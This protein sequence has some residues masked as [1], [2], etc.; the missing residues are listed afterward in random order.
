MSS[1]KNPSEINRLQSNNNRTSTI[2]QVSKNAKTQPPQP[3]FINRAT[4]KLPFRLSQE[5]RKRV[6]LI[7]L[8][9]ARPG[10]D[11]KLE[12]ISGVDQTNF[13]FSANRDGEYRFVFALVYDNNLVKPESPEKVAPHQ[14]IIVDRIPPQI[15]CRAVTAANGTTYLQCQLQDAHPLL[16]SLKIRFRDA[17]GRE[18]PLTAVSPESP[19][20]FPLPNGQKNSGSFV[21][22]AEDRAGNIV[23]QVIVLDEQGQG[24]IVPNRV[25]NNAQSTELV[26][27]VRNNPVNNPIVPGHVASHKSVDQQSLPPDLRLPNSK[28]FSSDSGN[29]PSGVNSQVNN[30]APIPNLL[31]PGKGNQLTPK[32]NSLLNNRNGSF[33]KFPSSTELVNS[34]ANKGVLPTGY[35]SP[36]SNSFPSNSSSLN[37]RQPNELPN[38]TNSWVTEKPLERNR[39]DTNLQNISPTP[40]SGSI[41]TSNGNSSLNKPSNYNSSETIPMP[42]IKQGTNINDDRLNQTE[43]LLGGGGNVPANLPAN[44]LAQKQPIE[45]QL[46]ITPTWINVPRCRLNYTIENTDPDVQNKTEFWATRD[47]GKTWSQLNNLAEAANQSPALLP[48]P[49]EGIFGIVIRANGNGTPPKSNEKPDCW[50]GVDTTKPLVNLLSTTLGKGEDKGSLLIVWSALDKNLL[51]DSIEIKYAPKPEGPWQSIVQNFRNDGTYRWLLPMGIPGHIYIRIEAS[52]LAG[53]RSSAMSPEPINLQIGQ[54]QVK[55]LGISPGR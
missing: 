29:N 5:T 35:N 12:Q 33:G 27:N 46:K 36:S 2:Q 43:N 39:I 15:G 19:T 50:V 4:F 51:E 38:Q 28:R 32:D 11:W 16:N 20:Y 25:Q 10:A 22:H 49:G 31:D 9:V 1:P 3:I 53:N 40:I 54:T 37:P 41:G 6:K 8:Y 13:E 17:S 45:E 23:E 26:T 7:R 47:Y 30:V 14:V 48:L 34:P 52:D 18:S 44:F 21:V 55:V 42:L 24:R